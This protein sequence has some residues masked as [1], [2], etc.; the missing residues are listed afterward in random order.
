MTY[1]FFFC[2]QGKKKELLGICE[3]QVKVLHGQTVGDCIIIHYL[4]IPDW[5]HLCFLK[6]PLFLSNEVFNGVKLCSK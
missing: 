5:S 3:K 4:N 6:G 2:L 1:Y